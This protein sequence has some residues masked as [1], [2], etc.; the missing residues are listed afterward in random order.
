MSVLDDIVAGVRIDSAGLLIKDPE[1]PEV[2]AAVLPGQHPTEDRDEVHDVYRSW[3]RIADS[4]DGTR[5][6]VGEVRGGHLEPLAQG[7]RERPGRHRRGHRGARPGGDELTG[8]R[9]V[10]TLP[11]RGQLY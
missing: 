4:Y 6:L 1:L 3:R 5:V 8:C 11:G 7:E 2:P 10:D 9:A